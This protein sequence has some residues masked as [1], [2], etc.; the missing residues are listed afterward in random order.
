MGV[1]W[2]APLFASQVVT[3]SRFARPRKPVFDISHRL[4]VV[5]SPFEPPTEMGSKMA[6]RAMLLD[7][8][9]VPPRRGSWA[10]ADC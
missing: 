4:S 3:V 2:V 1:N 5:H 10:I 7:R 6:A 9:A 8:S